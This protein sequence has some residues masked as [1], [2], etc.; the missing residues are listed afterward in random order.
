MADFL[1]DEQNKATDGFGHT[2][3]S[4]FRLEMPRLC[5]LSPHCLTSLSPLLPGCV[6]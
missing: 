1:P 6:L 4:Q 5:K 2:A 3:G